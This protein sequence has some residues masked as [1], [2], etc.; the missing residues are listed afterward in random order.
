MLLRFFM[1]RP[2]KS[3]RWSPLFG[4]SRLLICIAF[5]SV[6]VEF[7]PG[8][9]IFHGGGGLLGQRIVE[10]FDP[11]TIVKGSYENLLVRIGNFDGFLIKTRHVF[12]ERLVL[13]LTDVEETR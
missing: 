3:R 5:F 10:V 2:F 6:Y 4:I 8:I 7:C 1:S 12:L 9:D 11:Q 13:P